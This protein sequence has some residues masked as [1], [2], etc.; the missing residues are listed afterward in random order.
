MTYNYRKALTKKQVIEKIAAKI[1]AAGYTKDPSAG[2]ARH[3]ALEMYDDFGGSTPLEKYQ[4]MISDPV[5]H[6]NP[7][8][9]L[10]PGQL[11]KLPPGTTSI[12]LAR[13]G[14]RIEVQAQV[15]NPRGGRAAKNP[16]YT[17][18]Y[19][20]GKLEIKADFAQA[21]D[22]LKY[23]I[24]GAEWQSSPYQVADARHEVAEA[25]RLINSYLDQ[26]S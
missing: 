3:Q 2:S 24:D 6:R 22:S 19:K 16:I 15:G 20:W 14:A 17:R 8:K 18:T 21:S 23:R 5:F 10:N 9:Q 1:E 4:A 7:N 13:K 12:K 26:M 25:F 11:I